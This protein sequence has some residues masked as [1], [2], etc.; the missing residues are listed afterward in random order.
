M[1]SIN[2]KTFNLISAKPKIDLEKINIDH[3]NLCHL[4]LMISNPSLHKNII[5]KSCIILLPF[6]KVASKNNANIEI[7]PMGRHGMHLSFDASIIN[8]NLHR[9]ILVIV[10][11]LR[12]KKTFV[13]SR[14]SF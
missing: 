10:S 5:T 8:K 6:L 2:R 7:Q 4:D 14:S 9:I 12:G 13:F 11:D 1:F 3:L